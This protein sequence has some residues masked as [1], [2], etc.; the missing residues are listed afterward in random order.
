MKEGQ[1]EYKGKIR[2]DPRLRGT[3]S[4]A[5]ESNPTLTGTTIQ[6]TLQIV[7]DGTGSGSGKVGTT[8]E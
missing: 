3:E 7:N 5:E 4:L 2:Q 8:G 6:Q 1:L